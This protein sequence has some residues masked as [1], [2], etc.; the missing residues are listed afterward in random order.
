MT[1]STKRY[2]LAVGTIH[3]RAGEPDL[4]RSFHLLPDEAGMPSNHANRQACA[5]NARAGCHAFVDCVFERENRM[6]S[7]PDIA[8]GGHACLQRVPRRSS[9]FEQ[10]LGRRFFLE[11]LDD[12]RFGPE[13]EMDVTVNQSR[14]ESQTSSVDAGGALWN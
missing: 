13:T 5:D 10:R 2:R 9:G 14:Q 3:T 4:F 1:S 7:R 8:D 11:G 6:I 12:I